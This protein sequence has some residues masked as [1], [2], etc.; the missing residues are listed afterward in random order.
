MKAGELIKLIIDKCEGDLSVD[1][2]TSTLPS[3]IVDVKQIKMSVPNPDP[4]DDWGDTEK[5]THLKLMVEE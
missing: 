3:Q 2:V 4:L 1:V 5:I